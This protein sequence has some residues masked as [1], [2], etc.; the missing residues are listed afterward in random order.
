MKLSKLYNVVSCLVRL[1]ICLS[2]D[3]QA[4][5]KDILFETECYKLA[6][7]SIKLF[8]TRLC[9]RHSKWEYWAAMAAPL[10]L[11]GNGHCSYSSQFGD[12]CQYLQLIW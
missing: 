12:G 3:I 5:Y 6:T 8:M 10:F 11:V 7:S 4:C 1:M 2:R 9:A